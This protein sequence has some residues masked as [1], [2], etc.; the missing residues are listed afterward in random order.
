MIVPGLSERES[1]AAT[2]KQELL[3]AELNH[4][5]RNILG[6]IRG[7][8]A[9]SRNSTDDVD[10]FATILGDRVHALARAHDQ[11]T[12]K[13]WGPGSLANLIATEAAA[14]L[15]GGAARVIATGPDLL[16]QPQAFST[17]VLVIHEL[18]TN[19]AK[20]G[21]L[22]ND[23]GRV[24]I[25]WRLGAEGQLKLEWRESG[26]SPVAAPTRRGFGSAIIERSI[27]H[28]LGGEVAMD[29]AVAGLHARFTLPA[30]HVE[31]NDTVLEAISIADISAPAGRLSGTVLLVEDNMIIALESEDMLLEMGASEV[32]V[33][34]N[35]A[36]ALHLIENET[37]TF[38]LLD[39]NLGRE[40]SWP[41]ALRLRELRV[42]HVFGTGYGDGIDYPPEHRGT[43]VV[44]K[45]YSIVS[46]SRVVGR[47]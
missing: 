17:T 12:A 4:R 40:L 37:P 33:A 27:P 19:A 41:V 24:A 42:P 11:I 45:P 30:R 10:A 36:E 13:N 20:H 38:A 5:V 7:L 47:N 15:G 28:E 35:V 34:S 44:T 1:R 9:Q 29:F 43:P 3:I 39:I 21:A 32:L 26:G 31:R 16:L 46:L 14:F 23:A 25:D 6:L 8:V 18:M 22:A 2:Q